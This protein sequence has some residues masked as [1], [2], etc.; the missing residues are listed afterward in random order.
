MAARAETARLRAGRL[1]VAL[2]AAVLCGTAP[3]PPAA[4]D[5]PVAPGA[6]AA[7]EAP[8]RLVY[9]F[10][11]AGLHLASL[12]T[13][14]KLSGTRYEIQTRAESTGFADT[15]VRARLE[16]RASGAL[17]ARGPVPDRFRTFS[18][19]RFGVRKLEMERRADGTFDVTAEPALEPQQA[20]ALRSGLADGTL[21]PLTAS[22]YSVL[23][24]GSDA[25]T[26][27]VRVFDG[28]RVFKLA[29][30]RDGS[31]TL[32]PGAQAVFAGDAM[33]CLMRYV[34]LA[35]QSRE[36][37]LEEARNPSP[38]AALWLAP[39][40][41]EGAPAPLMLPVRMQFE[42]TWGA[43]LVHLRTAEIGGNTVVGRA[44][45]D[46]GSALAER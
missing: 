20:A 32:T 41:A 16:S 4:S 19:T 3:L 15:L 42:G 26:Q 13:T 36:W 25:C 28:R 12:E 8:I 21:D 22:I 31:D 33:K 27:D 14:A 23:R 39:F 30:S 5:A 10:Y 24:P 2:A 11:A 37:E 44:P 46:A 29:F 18:D 34:P 9:D 7:A 40:E 1:G 35:G 45:P 43:A 17:G 6:Q 38:P